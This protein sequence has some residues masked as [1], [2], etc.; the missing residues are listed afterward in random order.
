MVKQMDG[1]VPNWKS[2][3]QVIDRID[4]RA[5]DL[6]VDVSMRRGEESGGVFI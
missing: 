6:G 5:L 3:S 2:D 1:D 4:A